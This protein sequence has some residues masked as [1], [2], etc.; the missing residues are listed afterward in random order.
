MQ[1]KVDTAEQELYFPKSSN[2]PVIDWIIRVLKG[3]GIG[4]GFILP[5]L[6]GGVLA[7]I[8]GVYTIILRFLANM[9]RKFFEHVLFFIP[10]GIGG[11]IGI[12]LFS[13]VVS[14]AL[15]NYAT[16]AV[17][18]FIG[19]VVGTFPS[20]Y[21]KAGIQGRKTSDTT[22][23]LVLAVAFAALMIFLGEKELAQLPASF[24]S[25]LLA[26]GLIGL[27]VIVPGM[28][29]SNFLLYFGLYDKMTKGISE[30]DF[31]VIIPLFVGLVVCVILLAKLVEWLFNK[32][33]SKMYHF[34][35]GLVIG[36]SVAI[37]I[38]EVLPQLSKEA[39]AAKGTSQVT[40]ILLSVLCFVFGTVASWFFSKIEDK[41]DPEK[42][43]N[44]E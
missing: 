24:A 16:Q 44:V 31:S 37:V 4:I 14:V 3:I 41:Y 33:Y 19:F 6:S 27:G 17:S 28:S 26:G 34:I 21:K 2:N 30:L 35:L 40:A 42:V 32:Y 18:L 11:V 7:V 13:K 20:L 8:F 39:T 22:L 38:T 25:W 9:K 36:S 29:P 15:E 23:M 43:G 12:F 5:G 1:K 10:I